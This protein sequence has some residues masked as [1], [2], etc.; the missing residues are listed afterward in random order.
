MPSSIDF[1]TAA[2]GPLVLITAW[3][4][5]HDR[6][7]LSQDQ[8]VLIHGG[9]GGVGHVAVQLAK[10]AGARVITTVS[11]PQKAELARSLGADE[12]IDYRSEDVTRRVLELSGGEGVNIALD[13]V[14]PQV[15]RQSI[16]CVAHYGDLITLLDPGT[17]LDWKE[18]R[19]RNLRIGLVLMLTPMIRPLPEA[20]RRQIQILAEC[21]R[22][23]DAGRLR[24]QV[25]E[26]LDLEQAAEGHRRIE[27]GHTSGKIVLKT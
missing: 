19:N 9:A 17:D 1:D 14:G 16:P 18:A 11:S 6:A 3:E 20:R 22:L 26:A 2:A 7:R 24:L 25:G 13:T 10:A 4:A 23:I 8:S 27:S 5:L 15:F 12:T 21:A